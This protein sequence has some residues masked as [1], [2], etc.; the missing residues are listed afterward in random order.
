MRIPYAHACYG[1]EEVDAVVRVL[2]NPLQIGPGP[3]VAEFERRV[4]SLL[5]KDRGLMVNSGSSANLLALSALRLPEG[6]EVITPALTFATVVAPIMQL[7]LR[8]VFVDVEPG[9]YV[10]DV[11]RVAAAI[12]TKT[13]ALMIPLLLGNIPDMAA[14]RDLADAHQLVLIEDS[15]DTLGGTWGRLRAGHWSHISTTS[16]YASHVITCAG[17]GGLVAFNDPELARR[18]RLLASWGRASALDGLTERPAAE[19]YSGQ[20]GGIPYDRRFVFL[21]AGYNLQPTELQAAFGLEQLKRLPSFIE[22]R[23]SNAER[24]ACHLRRSRPELMVPPVVHPEADPCWLAFPIRLLGGGS[25]VAARRRSLAE[26]LEARGIQTRPIMTGNILRHPGFHHL[27]SGFYPWADD[28]MSS[29]LLVGCHQALEPADIDI[30]AEAL[31]SWT[32]ECAT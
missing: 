5:A 9:S 15:C 31:D 29:G 27:G 19:R 20:V 28:A 6:S 8:P 13:R 25:D 23:R 32:P 22:A 18:A 4:A 12:T 10:V 11:D 26:H 21:E 30:I 24:L 3:V 7:G 14:L 17:G 1:R 2:A 16:F